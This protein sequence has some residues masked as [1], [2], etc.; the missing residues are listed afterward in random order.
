MPTV[1]NPASVLAE[2]APTIQLPIDISEMASVASL[3]LFVTPMAKRLFWLR[4]RIN[5]GIR[6]IRTATSIAAMRG[7]PATTG[8]FC[9]LIGDDS[10]P[11][12]LFVYSDGP[13][14]M[15]WSEDKP[16]WQYASSY[17]SGAMWFSVLHQSIG[18]N[19]NSIAI[20]D[21]NGRL[22]ARGPNAIRSI[23]GSSAQATVQIQ[24]VG[25]GPTANASDGDVDL[26]G[27]V[28]I[29]VGANDHV[30]VDASVEFSY[31]AVAATPHCEAKL[32]WSIGGGW[33]EFAVTRLTL[34]QNEPTTAV[35]RGYLH[36]D[37]S[38]VGTA[39]MQFKATGAVTNA[40]LGHTVATNQGIRAQSVQ[41]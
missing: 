2:E 21:E 41:P 16:P 29:T 13:Y 19:T 15:G 34:R 31:D 5:N 38:M 14:T 27:S 8:E 4:D 36:V 22:K 39:T 3:Q 11:I 25:P 10:V 20:V 26:P 30:F 9:F 18:G 6:R 37:P 1:V 24:A 12:G 32:F 23:V 33:T 35:L 40:L 17:H 28:S 7:L